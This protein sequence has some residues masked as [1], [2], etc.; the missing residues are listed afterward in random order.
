[1]NL[2]GVRIATALVGLPRGSVVFPM[3]TSD[4]P[5]GNTATVPGPPTNVIATLSGSNGFNF[6]L[7]DG[8]DFLT[9]EDGMTL[10]E[11]ENG[12]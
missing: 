10:F 12:P 9:L 5:A 6:Y 2:S 7:E 1:M 4:A 8:V 3:T 11:Q